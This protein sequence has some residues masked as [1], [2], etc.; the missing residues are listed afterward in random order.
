MADIKTKIPALV[1]AGGRTPE[2]LQGVTSEIERSFIPICG[3]PIIS[4]SIDGVK[5]SQYLSSITMVG[6]PERLQELF[7]DEQIEFKYLVDTDSLLDNLMLGLRSLETYRSVLVM[8]SDIPLITDVILASTIQ[9]CQK[10]DAECYYPIV[11]KS[12]MEKKY[13]G[14][15]RTYVPMK[16]GH[17]TGGNIFLVSPKALLRN[18]KVFQRVIEDRKNPLKLAGL[19]GFSF[20]LKMLLGILDLPGL[21]KKATQILGV[22]V[23]AVKSPNPEVA[24]DVDKEKDYILVTRVMEKKKDKPQSS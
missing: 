4:H 7:H 6:N 21:E 19:F 5:N 8:T 13:P 12:L 2:A 11:A 24:L 1:L 10:D 14:G 20:I 18:E 16:E 23:K 17:F 15:K 22:T 9:E 3:K